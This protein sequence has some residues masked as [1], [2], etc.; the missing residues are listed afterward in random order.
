[1]QKSKSILANKGM[2]SNFADKEFI[3][4][5]E[6]NINLTD[7][8]EIIFSNKGKASIANRVNPALSMMGAHLC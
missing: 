4:T 8:D 5:K 6:E 7:V 3:S 1:M 2:K